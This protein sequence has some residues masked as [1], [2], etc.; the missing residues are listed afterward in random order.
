MIRRFCEQGRNCSSRLEDMW[1]GNGDGIRP[2]PTI[3]TK[4]LP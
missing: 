4:E 1:T 3:E 2:E